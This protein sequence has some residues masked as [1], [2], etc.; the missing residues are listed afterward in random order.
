MMKLQNRAVEA[1]KRYLVHKG[2]EILEIGW[3]CFAGEM[4]IIAKDGNSLVLADVICQEP[5][6]LEFSDEHNSDD[7]RKRFEKIA[8][9]FLSERDFL[10]MAVRFD[11]ISL[12]TLGTDRAMLRHH[13]SALSAA[14]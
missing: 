3:K 2:Y 11:V 5:G 12:V 6:N 8:L 10:D 14:A 7:K 9:A 13:K 4:D 1:A